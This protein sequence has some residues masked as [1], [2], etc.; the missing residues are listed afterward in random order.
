MPIK[1]PSPSPSPHLRCPCVPKQH[2]WRKTKTKPPKKKRNAS[3]TPQTSPDPPGLD[4][5]IGPPGPVGPPGPNQLFGVVSAATIL[6]DMTAGDCTASISQGD[7]EAACLVDKESDP[8]NPY[9]IAELACPPGQIALQ[10]GCVGTGPQAYV[11]AFIQDV[12]AAQCYYR[13][14]VSD[15]VYAISV[16][17]TC[18]DLE[19]VSS[20]SGQALK[21]SALRVKDFSAAKLKARIAGGKKRR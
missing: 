11:A 14:P 1:R 2:F 13:V 17:A 15:T 3:P 6:A 16:T 18:V 5:D 20:V 4:G 12:N 9:I 8:A 21:T 7:G 19:I 10:N